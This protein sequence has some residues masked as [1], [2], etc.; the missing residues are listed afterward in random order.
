MATYTSNLSLK[1]PAQSDKIRI[2]DLNGNA[3]NIDAA[4]G[5][6]FGQSSKPSIN[7]AIN[8]LADGLAIV[9]QGDVHAAISAGQ[10]VYVRNHSTL[11]EGLYVAS[12]AISANA[13]LSGTNLT[14]D[15]SGGLNALNSKLS[16]SSLTE[17]ASLDAVKTYLS[18]V[19]AT[20]NA[21][22]SRVIG[23]IS[24]FTDS[25]FSNGE[26]YEGNIY[27]ISN[28]LNGFYAGVLYSI[29]NANFVNFSNNNGTWTFNSVNSKIFIYEIGSVT[30]DSAGL[31]QLS[32]YTLPW[33]YAVLGA[34]RSA[35]GNSPYIITYAG[36][37]SN[38]NTMKVLNRGDMSAV[39]STTIS[40]VRLIMMKL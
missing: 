30:T 5:A 17:C 23:I 16:V 37:T 4:I 15:A 13:A 38:V 35:G 12:A 8:S 3:D 34:Y 39:A 10:F 1:K 6:D 11:A 31:F 21:R 19:I 29:T 20:M 9:A 2:A 40:D 27:Y 22:E 33:S 18:G 26:Y 32:E 28:N 25:G 7:A 24:R 14:A 36:H